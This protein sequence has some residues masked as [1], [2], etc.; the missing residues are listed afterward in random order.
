MFAG[1]RY[2]KVFDAVTDGE[3]YPF[4]NVLPPLLRRKVMYV[5]AEPVIGAFI[6]IDYVTVRIIPKPFR[7]I[8]AD[9]QLKIFQFGIM[10]LENR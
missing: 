9:L 6:I 7:W 5:N 8:I 4:R 10:I 3:I 2:V 1:A